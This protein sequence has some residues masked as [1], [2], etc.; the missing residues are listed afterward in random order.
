MTQNVE[1]YLSEHNITYIKHSH[2]PVFT[3]EE[4]AIHCKD[5]PGI[6]CKNLFL[7]EKE[8]STPHYFL[9][10]LPAEKRLNINALAKLLNIRKLTFASADELMQYLDLT[11]GSVSPLGLI[12]DTTHKVKVILDQEIWDAPL[13]NFHP[14]INTASLEFTSDQ[15]H[16][17][18]NTFLNEKKILPL[19]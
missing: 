2:P 4:A 9:V 3:V 11:P 7:K 1:E 12:N 5:V 15:F 14:N 16:K 19:P 18:M 13:I 17:L 6:A 10:I 8:T